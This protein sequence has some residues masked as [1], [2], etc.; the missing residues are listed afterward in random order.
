MCNTVKRGIL[1]IHTNSETNRTRHG[2]VDLDFV[3]L[4]LVNLTSVEKP[5]PCEDEV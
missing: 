4:I 2:R 1:T 5:N 3:T